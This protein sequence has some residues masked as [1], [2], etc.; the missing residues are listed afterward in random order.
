[1]TQWLQALSFHAYHTAWL[2]LHSGPPCAQRP[3]MFSG[4]K[5]FHLWLKYVCIISVPA[6]SYVKITA[7]RRRLKAQLTHVKL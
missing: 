2:G 5:G 6:P 3:N 7:C 1:M 4:C